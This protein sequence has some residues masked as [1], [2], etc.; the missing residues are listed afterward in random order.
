ML[1]N[2]SAWAVN[3]KR[4]SS[5]SKRHSKWRRALV[6]RL[7]DRT[8]LAADFALDITDGDASVEVGETVVYSFEYANVGDEAGNAVLRTSL[9]RHTV[10]DAAASDA[11]WSCEEGRFRTTYCSL[12]VGALQAETAGSAALAV[13]VDA[14]ISDR[15]SRISVYG[16][17]SGDSVR[18]DRNDGGHE[19]TQIKRELHDLRVSLSD[20]DAE[21][22]PGKSVVYTVEYANDGTADAAN[23]TISVRLSRGTSLDAGASSAGWTC[24][25]GVCKLDV[26]NIV[27]GEG[28]SRAL[29][30]TVDAESSAPRVSAVASISA[31]GT[32]A[33]RRD[34]YDHESTPITQQLPDLAVSL[35]DGYVDVEPEGTVTYTI[36]Y[37]NNGSVDASGVVVTVWV[38]RHA[39]VSS[40]GTDWTCEDGKCTLVI[41][42]L[43]AGASGF[44]TLEV[45]VDSEPS[46]RRRALFALGNIRDDGENGRDGNRRDNFSFERTMIVKHE[47]DDGTTG[48]D[49]DPLAEE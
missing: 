48:D 49:G 24:E 13:T 12:D 39:T 20:G 11:A 45:T 3:S 46:S 31:D 36:D 18:R 32:D 1:R 21:V 41:G 2:F 43:A 22:L 26:G 17:V 23:T 35:S 16:V 30:V 42:D 15:V 6:E 8:L 40:E 7:E 4:K 29:A 27:A 10:L 33:N 5:T 9:P 44:A 37:A 25:D 28:D 38:S 34:N 19:S 14:D 47:P